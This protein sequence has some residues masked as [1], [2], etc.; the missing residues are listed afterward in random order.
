MALR[1]Y[2]YEFSELRHSCIPEICPSWGTAYDNAIFELPAYMEFHWSLFLHANSYCFHDFS[3]GFLIYQ[4]HFW[5]LLTLLGSLSFV[6][7]MNFPFLSRKECFILQ[8]IAIQK[9]Y[10]VDSEIWGHLC[11]DLKLCVVGTASKSALEYFAL[12]G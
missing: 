6:C 11:C 7:L 3:T 5:S 8:E 4:V 9:D 2:L 1:G 10:S 12:K